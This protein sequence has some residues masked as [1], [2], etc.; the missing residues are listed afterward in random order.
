MS[1]ETT[2]RRA[3]ALMRER[4]EAAR[5][6]VWFSEGVEVAARWRDPRSVALTYGSEVPEGNVANAAHIA[7]WHPA[8][9][10]AVADL[11]DYLAPLADGPWGPDS[12]ID[13]AVRI[14]ECYLGES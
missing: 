1:A 13:R 12:T 10:L 8:V 9:T 2:L 5:A 14:A 11:L 6:G 4:A 7:S 3:A